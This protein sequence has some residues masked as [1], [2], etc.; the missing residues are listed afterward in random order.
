MAGD[1]LPVERLRDYLRQLKPEARALLIAELERSLCAAT[2]CSVPSWCCRSCVA[3]SAIPAA[4]PRG[5]EDVHEI[6]GILKVRHTLSAL[7]ERLP[8][9]IGNLAGEQLDAVKALLDSPVGRNRK[10][11]LY[12]LLMVMSRLSMPWQLIRLATK[13]ARSDVAA[14]VAATPYE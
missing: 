2:K 10:V 14:L 9:H 7:G 12:G 1:G 3:R 11:F 8:A 4:A 5:L 6:V 13:A